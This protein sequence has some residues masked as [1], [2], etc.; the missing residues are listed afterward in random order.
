M[1][2]VNSLKKESKGENQDEGINMPYL[3]E[4]TAVLEVAHHFLLWSKDAYVQL[5]SVDHIKGFLQK[6]KK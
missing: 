2:I 4:T 6:Y 1:I 3:T 5:N